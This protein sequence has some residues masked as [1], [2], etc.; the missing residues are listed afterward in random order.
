MAKFYPAGDDQVE[1]A[2]QRPGQDLEAVGRGQGRHAGR[3]RVLPRH[4]PHEHQARRPRPPDG[5]ARASGA[6]LETRLLMGLTQYRRARVETTFI[7][8]KV[9]PTLKLWIRQ[10]PNSSAA[11]LWYFWG[12]VYFSPFHE[13]AL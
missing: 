12:S 13:I 11:W 1:A 3:R 10:I 4:A 2:Q 7:C 9:L 5:P 6:P 8:I